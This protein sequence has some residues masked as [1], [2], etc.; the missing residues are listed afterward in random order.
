M[1]SLKNRNRR[2]KGS[3]TQ[4]R[5]KLHSLH[6][7]IS[8]DYWEQVFRQHLWACLLTALPGRWQWNLQRLWALASLTFPWRV[9]WPL[10]ETASH[11]RC[12]ARVVVATSGPAVNEADVRVIYHLTAPTPPTEQVITVTVCPTSLINYPSTLPLDR[13]HFSLWTHSAACQAAGWALN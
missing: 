3:K 1:G 5:W 2:W 6:L 8:G 11:F 10:L 4:L 13:K 12:G 9:G 7:S